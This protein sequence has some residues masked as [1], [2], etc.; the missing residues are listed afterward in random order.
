M[1]AIQSPEAAGD[2]H[3]MG[4]R[5]FAGNIMRLWE[6]GMDTRRLLL[7]QV[8]CLLGSRLSLGTVVW[9]HHG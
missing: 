7:Q 1:Q 2:R 5:R 8:L 4:M 6:N 3:L 9:Q